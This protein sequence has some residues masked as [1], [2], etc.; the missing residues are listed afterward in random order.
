MNLILI[1]I[2]WNTP[3]L[4]LKIHIGCHAKTYSIDEDQICAFSQT[5][6][7][8]IRRW[9]HIIPHTYR[10]R[11]SGQC[12][13]FISDLG[14]FLEKSFSSIKKKSLQN[15][16]VFRITSSEMSDNLFLRK[17]FK[18]FLS[19][20]PC[21]FEDGPRQMQVLT[22]HYWKLKQ[23][24]FKENILSAVISNP[25]FIKDDY[26]GAFQIFK[27]AKF[28]KSDEPSDDDKDFWC[29]MFE[30]ISPLKIGFL[31]N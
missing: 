7:N 18:L 11:I 8:F 3:D 21:L 28:S 27:I 20:C 19:K 4:S 14:S 22:W 16:C 6:H 10:K 13:E 15:Y 29:P 31:V 25:S 12:D 5:P 2:V 24:L 23:R 1:R 26:L 9:L 17:S 30:T